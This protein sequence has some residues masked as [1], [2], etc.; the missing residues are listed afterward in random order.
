MRVINFYADVDPA[1]KAFNPEYEKAAEEIRE[2]DPTVVFAR[3]DTAAAINKSIGDRVD[4]SA[5]GIPHIVLFKPNLKSVDVFPM[6]RNAENL[7]FWIKA[8]LYN[9]PVVNTLEAFKKMMETDWAV[10]GGVLGM[11]AK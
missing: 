6:K 2:A 4:I 7:V 1:S 9:C 11:F 3:V 10:T 8:R 5:G